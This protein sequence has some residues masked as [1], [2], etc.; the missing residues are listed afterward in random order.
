MS[1]G[2]WK[3]L[4]GVFK[5]WKQSYD[6]ILVNTHI[7]E[8]PSQRV[9]KSNLV[10]FFFFSFHTGSGLLLLLFSF[11]SSFLFFSHWVS[12]FGFFFFLFFFH[13][14][15]GLGFSILLFF[16]FFF[17]SFIFTLGFWVWFLFFFFS[18]LSIPFH[19]VQ[20]VWVLGVEGGKKKRSKSCAKSIRGS[21][22]KVKFFEL[23]KLETSV[24]HATLG[25][26]GIFSDKWWV[27]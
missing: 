26:C 16:F 17:F 1:Y 22:K 20:W 3:Q 23:S 5:L 25:S 24:K 7:F 18:F 19:W 2:N 12:R 21:H 10:F 11:F 6:G 4:L 9:V 27:I 15:S 13:A 14:G 8:R